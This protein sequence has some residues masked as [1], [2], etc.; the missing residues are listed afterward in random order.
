[1]HLSFVAVVATFVSV[2][3]AQAAQTVVATAP[4]ATSALYSGAETVGVAA[5]VAAVAAMLL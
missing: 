1:M 2:A 5:A 3:A 4:P